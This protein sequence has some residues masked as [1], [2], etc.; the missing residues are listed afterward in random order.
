MDRTF[1][2]IARRASSR[3][4]SR[5]ANTFAF[6]NGRKKGLFS[7]SSTYAPEEDGNR[8]AFVFITGQ[9]GN[10]RFRPRRAI[11]CIREKNAATHAV[12]A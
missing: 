1:D 10:G 11:L 3:T 6:E 9:I 4:L 2:Q 8:K 5:T 7:R 12:T